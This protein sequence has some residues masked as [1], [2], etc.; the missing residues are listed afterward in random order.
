[1]NPVTIGPC[2]LYHG[3]CLQIAPTLQGVDAV[4]TDPPFEQ[5][6]HT[7]QRRINRGKTRGGACDSVDVESIGFDAIKESERIG[8]CQWA[9]SNVSGWF[10]AFC[11]AEAVSEWRNAM[12]LSGVSYKRAMVWIKPDGMPQYSGDRPGMGYESIAAGWCGSGRS[13]WNGGGSHGVFTYTKNSGGKHDHPTQKP[14][15]LMERLL[16]LFSNSGHLV[17]DP[18][19]GSGTTGVACIR[20]GRRFIGIEIDPK[21]FKTACD[22]IQHEVD[23]FQLP[24]EIKPGP[25]QEALKIE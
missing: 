15:P 19:M 22:R 13:S 23:Q 5:E 16:N 2:T 9:G 24:L 3:D 4:V 25:K 10:L 14:V 21:H 18:F 1:M 11:Q 7:L 17:L 20:T 6:A 12:S 8:I